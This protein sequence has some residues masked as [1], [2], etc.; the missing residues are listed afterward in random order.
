MS[1]NIYRAS[2]SQ[3]VLL[4]RLTH[5]SLYVCADFCIR[6]CRNRVSCF[7]RFLLKKWKTLIG[8]DKPQVLRWVHLQFTV[9]KADLSAN[10]TVGDF[11][12]TGEETLTCWTEDETL[13]H[14][15][16]YHIERRKSTG[17][18]SIILASN[19]NLW[20]VCSWIFTLPTHLIA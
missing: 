13:N 17:K 12:C 18:L 1:N 15:A 19:Q 8:S 7:C 4:D 6:F 2:S 9:K 14:V 20:Q 11:T 10:I 5:T 16:K 3:N